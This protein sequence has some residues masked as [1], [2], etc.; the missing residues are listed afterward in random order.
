MILPVIRFMW[1]GSQI[2]AEFAWELQRSLWI[3]DLFNLL[4]INLQLTILWVGI[5]VRRD[6]N[7]TL[8]VGFGGT[9]KFEQ[10]G[11]VGQGG[12]VKGERVAHIGRFID[13]LP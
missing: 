3:K 5:S 9:C 6:L 4:V 1:K 10:V 11:A 2:K 13:L 12:E 8:L 7:N